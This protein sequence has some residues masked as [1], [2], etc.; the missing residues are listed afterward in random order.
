MLPAK[1]QRGICVFGY[2]T[3]NQE[4]LKIKDFKR[5]RGY[6]C[7]LCHS[8]KERYGLKGQAILPND[9]AFLDILLNGLYEEPL[10]ELTKGCIAH[11]MKKQLMLFNDITDYC[12][13]MG[14]LLAYC[15]C[16]DDVKDDGSAKAKAGVRMLK[17]HAAKVE[18]AYPRQSEAVRKYIEDLSA[19]EENNEQDLDAAAGLTGTATGEIFV[20]RE[21]DIWADVLRRMGFFL[22]KFV[23]LMDA[24]E[25]LPD[26][27]KKNR[28]N[29]WESYKD[30][31]DFD[32]LVEN[33]LTMMMSE[34]AREF[35]KLPILQDVE[36]LR[37][38]IYSGVWVKYRQIQKKRNEKDDK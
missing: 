18:S 38:I 9:M 25:D 20:M 33:V 30:R 12:A 17:K 8:L 4:E 27:E 1:A 35:E 11:P 21:E 7:G 26:D 31:K 23:Y 3:I 36:I 37:N 5:Y 16:L 28:Y 14:L 32:A 34:C 29:P 2:V 19:A 22:G 13:D 24:Y 6:Y 15:K 10:T